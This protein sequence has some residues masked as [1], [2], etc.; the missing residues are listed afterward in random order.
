MTE[1]VTVDMHRSLKI[2][3]W[4]YLS[5]VTYNGTTRDRIGSS[6]LDEGMSSATLQTRSFGL[7]F[8]PDRYYDTTAASVWEFLVLYIRTEVFVLL[9]SLDNE[10]RKEYLNSR[11]T[12]RRRK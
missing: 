1:V 5:G 6:R 3:S 7:Y 9:R 10:A 12:R 4:G 8:V 2:C 11:C